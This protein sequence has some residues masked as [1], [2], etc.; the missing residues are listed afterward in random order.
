MADPFDIAAAITPPPIDEIAF[1]QPRNLTSRDVFRL[2]GRAWPFIRPYRRHLVFLF[3]MMIP[4]LPV[5]LF[6]LH[7]VR[8]L[9][10]VVGHGKH[11]TPGEAWMLR[12]APRSSRQVILWHACIASGIATAIG[13]PYGALMLGYAVWILQRISNLFRVNLYARSAGAQPALS[14]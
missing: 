2:L 13:A 12:V 8:V 3:L 1:A 14:F 11:L 5:G 4:A 10:D 6:A 9:F 7:M